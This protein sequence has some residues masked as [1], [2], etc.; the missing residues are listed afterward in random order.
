MEEQKKLM[1]DIH[2]RK[3]NHRSEHIDPMPMGKLTNYYT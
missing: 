3:V 1:E 2:K